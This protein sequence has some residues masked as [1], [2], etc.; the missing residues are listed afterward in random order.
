MKKKK[1]EQ[2]KIFCQKREERKE[3]RENKEKKIET[4]FGKRFFLR[5]LG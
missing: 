1:K 2:N 3:G 5:L 4:K